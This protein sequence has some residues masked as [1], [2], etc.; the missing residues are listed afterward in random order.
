MLRIFS[1]ETEPFNRIMK[2][3]YSIDF[4]NF[5]RGEIIINFSQKLGVTGFVS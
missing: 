3:V 5:Y 2:I 1:P 4:L